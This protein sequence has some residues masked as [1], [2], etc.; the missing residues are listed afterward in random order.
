MSWGKDKIQTAIQTIEESIRELSDEDLNKLI[1]ISAT[2]TERRE[3]VNYFG[4]NSLWDMID[5]IVAD[6]VD[7]L[8]FSYIEDISEELTKSARRYYISKKGQ[9]NISEELKEETVCIC[10]EASGTWSISEC[11]NDKDELFYRVERVT[12]VIRRE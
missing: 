9:E 11:Y 12:R 10:A 2:E 3:T 6:S 5:I 1:T 8:D 4:V 7:R